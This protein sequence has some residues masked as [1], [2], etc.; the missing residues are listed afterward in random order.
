MQR[1]G[2][3][4]SAYEYESNGGI[5]GFEMALG[6][7]NFYRLEFFEEPKVLQ[8]GYLLVRGSLRFSDLQSWS[9]PLETSEWPLTTAD[10]MLHQN[11]PQFIDYH[12]SNG[13]YLR[14]IDLAHVLP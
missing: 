14:H 8:Y 4:D 12:G 10:S 3:W 1:P 13:E 6:L 9:D 5:A 7:G 11:V 2:K